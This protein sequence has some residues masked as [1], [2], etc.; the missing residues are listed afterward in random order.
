MGV[1][2]LI[3]LPD[4]LPRLLRDPGIIGVSGPA[5]EM[6][7]T[8][9]QFDEEEHVQR[10]QANSLD[11]EEIAREHVLSIVRQKGAP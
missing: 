11:R 3:Q 10:L 8:R 6:D 7:T 2:G 1:L 5:G 9:A 4:E